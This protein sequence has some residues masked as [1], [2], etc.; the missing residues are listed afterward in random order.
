MCSD[1]DHAVS[2]EGIRDGLRSALF[3]YELPGADIL[4]GV[5][6]LFDI[7]EGRLH[8]KADGAGKGAEDGDGSGSPVQPEAF[9]ELV[10]GLSP[11]LTMGILDFADQTREGAFLKPAVRRRAA[12]LNDPLTAAVLAANYARNVVNELHTAVRRILD[13]R[14]AAAPAGS[15]E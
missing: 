6:G 8:A 1:H 12:G 15:S 5:H 3:K 2:R 14:P 11:V 13:G 7:A 9:K 4:A 10:N